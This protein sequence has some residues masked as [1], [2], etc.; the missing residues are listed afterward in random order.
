M[1][2][3]ILIHFVEILSKNL[4]L[5]SLILEFLIFERKLNF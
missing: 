2:E 3:Y 4:F 1:H 5:I